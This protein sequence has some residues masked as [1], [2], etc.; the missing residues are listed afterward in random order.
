MRSSTTSPTNLS[1][2]VLAGFDSY[3][4]NFSNQLMD[5]FIKGLESFSAIIQPKPD[6]EALKRIQQAHHGIKPSL[7][8]F[9]LEE[10][11]TSISI[12]LSAQNNHSPLKEEYTEKLSAQINLT[13]EAARQWLSER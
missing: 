10:L 1:F 4:K 13:L 2:E 11:S 7:T 12:Y 6:S 5:A 9:E 3:D 8:L